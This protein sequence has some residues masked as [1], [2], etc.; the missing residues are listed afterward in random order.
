MTVVDTDARVEPTFRS[1]WFHCR[2]LLPPLELLPL[3]GE[4]IAFSDKYENLSKSDIYDFNWL[5]AIFTSHYVEQH[6]KY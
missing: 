5:R 4:G 2:A 6:F 1:T 3:D